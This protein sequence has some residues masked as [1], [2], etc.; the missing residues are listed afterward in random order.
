MVKKPKCGVCGSTATVHHDSDNDVYVVTDC[1]R[2]G[3]FRCA[4]NDFPKVSSLDQK[5]ALASHLIRRMQGTKNLFL[6][7][8][9]FSSLSQRALPTPAEMTDNLL[10][11]IAD[12][13]EERPGRPVS[14]NYEEP[15]LAALIGA[16]DENDVI[17]VVR[18][19]ADKNLLIRGNWRGDLLYNAYLSSHGWERI[20]ELKLAHVTSRYAFFA[21][22]FANHDLD[23][24][25]N[26]CLKQA[27]ADTG[28]ELRIATQM[29]GHIDAIVEDEIRRCRFLIADLS[30]DNAGA[31]WEAGFAEGLGKDVIYV[32]RDK[33]NDGKTDKKTHFDTDHRQTVRWDLKK[34]DN[35]AK[36]LKAVI[37]NTL[38]GDAKQE[39]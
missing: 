8:E 35:T 25:Y 29:A 3:K 24:L 14:I 32:C 4:T 11:W 7:T 30:D 20:E 27:V 22:K 18:D 9:F 15:S 31:Y 12:G 26:K 37:R 16:V 39:D 6:D 23:I 10:L 1:P 38:L 5:W 21:R 34:L 2:C 19:V 17:W 28:Y 33:E 13:I 36:Q